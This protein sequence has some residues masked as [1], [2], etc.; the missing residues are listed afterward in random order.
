MAINKLH[1]TDDING[2]KCAIVERN[3]S[4]DRCVFLKNLLELNLYNVFIK[5]V[6]S[7]P[8]TSTES[9]TNVN[10]LFILGVDNLL[11]NTTNALYGRAIKDHRGVAVSWDYWH[12]KIKSNTDYK[13]YFYKSIE[14]ENN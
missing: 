13:P 3:I 1:D 11:F 9:E 7:K 6:D 4:Y 14:Y 12:Q 2:I 5:P 8:T 10:V